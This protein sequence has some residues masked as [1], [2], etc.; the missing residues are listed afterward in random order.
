MPLQLT[1]SRLANRSASA[2]YTAFDAYQKQFHAI[3]LR[4]GSRFERRQW[5]NMRA[6]ASERLDLYKA[7]VDPAVAHIRALVSERVQEKEIWRGMKAVYSAAIETR[8]DWELAETF[9]NSITRRIFSTVGVD[10]HI[11]FVDSDF[12]APPTPSRVPTRTYHRLESPLAL[13]QT[14]LRDYRPAPVQDPARDSRWIATEIDARLRGSGGWSEVARVEMCEAIFYRD[15]RAYLIGLIHATSE[16]IPLVIALTHA[17]EGVAVDTVLTDEN[18]V[19][20]LFSFA[21]SHFHVQ[22]ARP[23]DLVRFLHHIMP[24]KRIAELY[25]SIGYHKQ[26]KTELYRDFLHHLAES[27]DQFDIAAGD[28]GMV[29]TVFTL[30]SYDIVFKLFKDQFADPKTSTRAQVMDKYN[31]VFRHDRAGRLIDAQ[32]FEHLEIDRARFSEK[33]LV[34]LARLAGQAVMIEND[35]VHIRH[36]YVERRVTP[37]NLFLRQADAATAEQAVIDYG[38]AI[39]DLAASNIFPGD[40]L[41]K[42]FGVTRHG[43]VVFY[44][45]DELCLLTECKFSAMPLPR[46]DIEELSSEAWYYVADNEIFPEEFRT[47]LGL[48]TKLR[49]VFTAHHGDLFDPEFWRGTQARL[50]AGELIDIS[51]Y[52]ESKRLAKKYSAT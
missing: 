2:I 45:Y 48:P 19:S 10:K 25:I 16:R 37:L 39:K 22:I 51:P 1:D 11:E 38:H 41:L 24:R 40:V 30:P 47:F 12:D 4:A 42:N 44:D 29:M 27:D 32:E 34:E 14:L 8:E 36:A 21:R 18:D 17:T 49:E 3:T 31:L 13:A 26:G 23:Y 9:F 28:R 33:L 50:A 20:I 43:R 52:A 46:N 15:Q 5:H 35:R 6:D 7:H